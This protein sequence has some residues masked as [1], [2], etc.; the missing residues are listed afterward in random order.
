VK[1]SLLLVT[2]LLLIG[3]EKPKY[4]DAEMQKFRNG[5]PRLT[6][7]C[8]DKIQKGGIEAL[9][10]QDECYEMLPAARWRGLWRNDFEGSLFCPAPAKECTNGSSGEAIWLEFK[11]RPAAV[12]EAL[13]GGLY[14]VDFIGRRTAHGD[15][16]VAAGYAQ[17]MVVDR[18]I[19]MRKV[20]PKK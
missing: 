2:A 10:E 11:S 14:E 5:T 15:G 13:P 1:R 16:M 17:D 20:E 8:L 7:A 18:L 4:T 3:C 12:R 9:S 19:S 6:E